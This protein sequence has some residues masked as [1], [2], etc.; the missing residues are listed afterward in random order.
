M[1]V[2]TE[3]TPPSAGQATSHA[4]WYRGVTGY[5]WLIL[6]IA[7]AG[8]VFD[9]FEGQIFIITRGDM[10][11][12]VMQVPKDS[13]PDSPAMKQVKQ[14]GENMNGVFLLGGALGGIGFGTL[15]D[16]WGRKPVLVLTILFYSVFAGL[17]YFVAALWQV[18]VLRFLVAVGVGGEWA[19]AAALVAEVF[20]QHSRTH[21]SGIFHATSALGTVLAPVVGLIV[22][23][24]WRWAYLV[25]ILPALLV[26][27]VIAQVREPES[28]VNARDR[29][30]GGL[31]DKLGSFREM[32][33]DPTWGP[34]ALLGTLLAAVG[35]ATCWAVFAAG[36]D[37]AAHIL[38]IDLATK[39]SNA[40]DLKSLV[41]HDA[42]VA[43][44]FEMVGSALGM[45][46][47]GP[48]CAR[49]GRRWTF[50]LFQASA[51]IV[52]PIT[53]F[54][55]TSYGGLLALMPAYGFCTLA[56][57]AGFAIYFPELFPSRLRSTGAGFC[58]NAGR[59]IAAPVLFLSGWLKA[60]PSMTLPGAIALMNLLFVFGILLVFVL[61]ETKGRPLPE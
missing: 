7:S 25:S 41:A 10:L 3:D 19:V 18:A 22:G 36:K 14:Q 58:F 27:W 1:P 39:V 6:I 38:Q 49:L 45:L 61:P 9:A 32:F 24:Q 4:P 50:A 35:L 57:H 42:N 59:L 26:V 11:A 33:G 12:E 60:L 48:V 43:Y 55:V 23:T 8:W 44:I 13:A 54:G 20:P 29:A 31:G 5:Q 47:F 21:A 17:T 28:W 37:L 52:V 56:I 16:R 2:Q 51:L 46:S 53:C 34:R 40:E 15:A 30:A